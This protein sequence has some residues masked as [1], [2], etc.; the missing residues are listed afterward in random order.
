MVAGLQWVHENI[1]N[2]GGDSSQVTIFGE[3]AGSWG[4]SYLMV[5]P[6]ARVKQ[7]N[8]YKFADFGTFLLGIIHQSYFT[9][10]SMDSSKYTTVIKGRVC[11][12]VLKGCVK[13]GKWTYFLIDWLDYTIKLSMVKSKQSI[14]ID[15]N[16]QF[17]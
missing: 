14:G 9:K 11:D 13:N 16:C 5:S 7:N 6:L 2:F 15:D 10:W 12:S 3:S 17:L 8:S 1:G 4:C